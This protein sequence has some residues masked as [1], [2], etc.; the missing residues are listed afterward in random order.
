[1]FLLALGLRIYRLPTQLLWLD[2]IYTLQLVRE[3]PLAILR[4][5]LV[6]PHPPLFFLFDW[7]ASGFGA[8][9]SEWGYRW[10]SVLSGALTIPFF[11]LLCQ[12]FTGRLISVLLGI[13]LV[14]SPFH[15]Y[16][17][18]E[19]RPYAFT[20]LVAVLTTLQVVDILK[21][22][23]SLSRWAGLGLLS[24]VG[25]FCS[26]FYLLIIGAQG[27]VLF[28]RTRQSGWWLYA[29]IITIGVGAA[30]ILIVPTVTATAKQHL[31]TT[32]LTLLSTLQSLAGEPVR[33]TLA[34]QHWCLA[35]LAGG[36]A[37]LGSVVALGSS[38]KKPIR[39]YLFCQ[40]FLPL[41]LLTG[42]GIYPGINLPPYESRQFLILMPFLFGLMALGLDKLASRLGWF[43]PTLLCAAIL[44]ASGAGLQAYWN[45]QKSPEGSLVLNIRS[46]LKPGEA[47]VS[48]H[49]SLTAGADIYLPDADVWAYRG[50]D[51]GEYHFNRDLR[52][53]QIAKLNP[54][55][56]TEITIAEI[57]SYPRFWVLSYMVSNPSVLPVL[58]DQCT[59]V[60]QVSFTPFQASLWES[61]KP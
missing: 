32:S 5:S 19:A 13:I 31:N 17:S 23:R 50:E 45:Y 16:Y 7:L 28:L 46:E 24:L 10:L 43:I 1:L 15:I 39:L 47:V 59:L 41:I 38:Y 11:Y 40:C 36:T 2:E 18:Q 9:Q 4:N 22:R 14:V 26:Y 21:G 48:L 25:L 12:R 42:L 55:P 27:L 37:L 58:T 6:D 53:A 20:A 30:A 49:Y 54:Q 29:A 33:I 44:F 57:R 61:C 51:T 52:L 34:W 56:V 3:G 35:G 60:K 8:A